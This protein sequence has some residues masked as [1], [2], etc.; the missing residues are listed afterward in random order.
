VSFW[1]I[2]DHMRR[3]VEI[4]AQIRGLNRIFVN[5]SII[6]ETEVTFTL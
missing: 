3:F 5:I 1:T 4:S 2:I 6:I